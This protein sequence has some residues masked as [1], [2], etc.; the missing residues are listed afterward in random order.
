M[1]DH[2]Q[3]A[4]DGLKEI[5]AIVDRGTPPTEATALAVTQTRAILAVAE[6][7]AKTNEHLQTGNLIAYAQLCLAGRD[8]AK[9]AAARNAAEAA[10]KGAS[11]DNGDD[12]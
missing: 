3:A 7:Q 8:G 1:N 10:M 12:F 11:D 5:R 6:E 4:M 2:Y 9:S